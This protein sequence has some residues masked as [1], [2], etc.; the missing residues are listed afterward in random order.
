MASIDLQ[1]S[2]YSVPVS[3][4]FLE[5]EIHTNSLACLMVLHQPAIFL[6]KTR[7]TIGLHILFSSNLDKS[8]QFQQNLQEFFKSLEKVD[9][10]RKNL[11]KNF[12]RVAQ[13]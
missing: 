11:H 1:D 13:Y 2:Y 3:E 10:N 4:N 8:Y 9:Q 5:R 12:C 7:S 6:Q